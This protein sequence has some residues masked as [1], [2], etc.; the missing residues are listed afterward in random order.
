MTSPMFNLPEGIA[1]GTGSTPALP[2]MAK[3]ERMKHHAKELNRIR[4]T[5]GLNGVLAYKQQHPEAAPIFVKIDGYVKPPVAPGYS[6]AVIAMV[7]HWF[8]SEAALKETNTAAVQR[9]NEKLGA[10]FNP[11]NH[12]S[13]NIP[14][15]LLA[16]LADIFEHRGGYLDTTQPRS[17]SAVKKAVQAHKSLGS[18]TVRPFGTVGTRTNDTL[19]VAGHTYR[20]EDHR[21]RECIRV[22]VDGQRTRIPLVVLEVL[23][24]GLVEG[25]PLFTPLRSIRELAPSSENS[26]SAPPEQSLGASS[27]GEP[28]RP[29]SLFERIDR[30]AQDRATAVPGGYP[31]LTIPE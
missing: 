25:A 19:T 14:S 1:H 3:A 23:Y 29:L 11:A 31:E 10:Q 12:F 16:K 5:D 6:S 4:F 28:E 9:L 13:K 8:D 15:T 2:T 20:I 30:L 21:G 27:P 26:P 22:S 24:A 7:N 17:I 18:S